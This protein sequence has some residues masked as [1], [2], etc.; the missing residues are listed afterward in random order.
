MVLLTR[1][2]PEKAP[3][4]AIDKVRALK[5]EADL[6]RQQEVEAQKVSDEQKEQN[7]QAAYEKEKAEL[8]SIIEKRTEVESMLDDVKNQ[9]EKIIQIGHAAVKEAKKDPAVEYVI[10]TKEGFDEVF[11]GEKAQW[12]ELRQKVTEYNQEKTELETVLPKKEG[13]VRELFNQTAEGKKMAEETRQANERQKQEALAKEYL[14]GNVSSYYSLDELQKGTWDV[15]TIRAHIIAELPE[16]KKFEVV[17]AVKTE[18]HKK[19][20]QMYETKNAAGLGKIALDVGRIREY[21]AEVGEVR[22]MFQDYWHDIPQYLERYKKAFADEKSEIT[23]EISRYFGNWGERRNNNLVYLYEGLN[24]EKLLQIKRQLEIPENSNQEVPDLN[25]VK[26]Y[27]E[28]GRK[29]NDGLLALIESGNTEEVKRIFNDRNKDWDAHLG[30]DTYN[31][32]RH[33]MDDKQRLVRNEASA[34]L[35]YGPEGLVNYYEKQIAIQNEEKNRLIELTDAGVDRSVAGMEARKWQTSVGDIERNF[36]SSESQK[37][38]AESALRLV[39][40][41]YKRLAGKLSEKIFFNIKEVGRGFTVPKFES[42]V[43]QIVEYEQKRKELEAEM[44]IKDQA[45]KDLAN[46]KLGLFDS[47]SKHADVVTALEKVIRDLAGEKNTAYSN[48]RGLLDAQ[49]DAD[50]ERLWRYLGDIHGMKNATEIG[51]T[52]GLTVNEMLDMIKTKLT[53]ITTQEFPQDRKNVLD[54]YKKGDARF[55]AAK[56]K[57]VEAKR[58]K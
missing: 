45:R 24:N 14:P 3:L 58:A 17:E 2:D 26:K 46:K 41:T 8:Q 12:Q 16:D 33:L 30:V 40:D 52:D 9:R 18:L 6:K 37:K 28:A 47:K 36:L 43:K 10:R 29:A 57:V 7:I 44:T 51:I 49:G 20:D 22:N 15:N 56:E 35:K 31:A 11:A 38:S 25:A 34:S 50:L 48:M 4:S 21:K 27:V 32:A 19:L 55:Q 13:T 42:E 1:M 39:G 23:T 5:E 53:A 54:K